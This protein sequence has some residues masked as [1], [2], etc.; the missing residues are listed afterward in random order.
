MLFDREDYLRD[1]SDSENEHED[2]GEAAGNADAFIDPRIL[3]QS[4]IFD[5]STT[6]ISPGEPAKSQQASPNKEQTIRGHALTHLSRRQ[7]IVN[8]LRIHPNFNLRNLFGNMPF[9]SSVLTNNYPAH[10]QDVQVNN[11]FLPTWAMM[12]VNT[13]PDPGSLKHAFYSLYGE[14]SALLASGTPME[15]IIEVHPNIAALFDEEEYYRSGVLSKWVVGVVHSSRLKGMDT[16]LY[17][18]FGVFQLVHTANSVHE[19]SLTIS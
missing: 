6:N 18:L 17:C 4:H 15:A 9:S 11:L 5:S 8:T 13:R 14:T 10:I 2:E 1:I 7:P 3:A 16:V 19:G 12:T